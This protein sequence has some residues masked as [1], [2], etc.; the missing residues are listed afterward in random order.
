VGLPRIDEGHT[1]VEEECPVWN[2]KRGTS[3]RCH[4]LD[5]L[6][7]RVPFF[8]R[9]RKRGAA[10]KHSHLH[11]SD[12][13]ERSAHKS[14]RDRSLR[15]LLVGG[16]KARLEVSKMENWFRKAALECSSETRPYRRSMNNE[17]MVQPRVHIR[18]LNPFTREETIKH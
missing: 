11:C 3:M 5:F 6:D 1:L 12:T 9:R 7:Y 16:Q 2:L 14:A 4:H 8:C 17:R 18:T 13:P 10:R 15:C